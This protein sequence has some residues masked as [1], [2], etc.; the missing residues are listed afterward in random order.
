MTDP[1][2]G[3]K[4]LGSF[5]YFRN[6]DI[7]ELVNGFGPDCRFLADSGAFSAMTQG[8]Q[9][10]LSNYAQWVHTWKPYLTHYINLD[11]IGDPVVTWRNQRELED[12]GLAPIPV[13]HAGSDFTHLYRY[14]D[15]G[16]TYICLGGLVGK[17][18]KAVM[19][20][21][22][23]CFKEARGKAV[24]HGLG[25]TRWTDLAA[26][27][28]YSVDSS[29]WGSGSRFGQVSLWDS[30][31]ARFVGIKL[32]SP[33]VRANLRL[34]REHGG[35]PERLS[36]RKKYVRAD[37]CRISAIAYHRLEQWLRERHGAVTLA[38]D[39][40]GLHLYLADT[41]RNNDLKDATSG[42]LRYM[43]A[44]R[45]DGRVQAAKPPPERRS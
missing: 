33:E 45:P 31:R 7:A 3:F 41:G 43:A 44:A 37:V 15:T 22:I 42:L 4:A 29:S 10:K 32:G 40:D 25:L 39:A 19:P 23:K 26:L 2:Q 14:L 34:I 27:P 9:I 13:F 35:D 20:W 24:F 8:V 21:A 12:Q 5:H 11:V 6:V 30:R 1:V 36:D 16:Y 28:Y 18:H 17:R 38:D